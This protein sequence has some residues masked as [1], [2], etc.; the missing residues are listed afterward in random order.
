M[1]GMLTKD[2]RLMLQQKRFFILLIFIA[3]FI[4]SNSDANFKFKLATLVILLLGL[5]K[6][7]INQ[8]E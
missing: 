5:T 4:N 8:Y 1:K 2:I 6:K 3:I 7:L